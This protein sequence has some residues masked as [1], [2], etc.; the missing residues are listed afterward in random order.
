MSNLN[1]CACGFFGIVCLIISA[2]QS[3][4]IRAVSTTKTISSKRLLPLKRDQS[5]VKTSLKANDFIEP[6]EVI[7]DGNVSS[8]GKAYFPASQEFDAP[9]TDI[10]LNEQSNSHDWSKSFHGL[11]TQP[12]S[13]ETAEILMQPISVDDIEIKPGK[14]MLM[15]DMYV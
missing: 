15:F 14:E 7:S 2:Q 4:T 8:D 3:T 12:F 13:P 5:T 11:S 1:H 10:E 6:E 9:P